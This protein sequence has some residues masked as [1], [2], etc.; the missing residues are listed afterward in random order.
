M[1]DEIYSVEW[2]GMHVRL[3][4]FAG[5]AVKFVGKSP[6]PNILTYC[7]LMVLTYAVLVQ[8][9]IVGPPGIA[10]SSHPLQRA[11]ADAPDLH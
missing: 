3:N 9:Q 5:S 1:L 8:A 2:N 6:L 7:L 11:T 10:M 4:K